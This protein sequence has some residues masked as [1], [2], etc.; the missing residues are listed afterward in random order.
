[1]LDRLAIHYNEREDRLELR[2]LTKQPA[3]EYRFHLTRRV[4][5]DWLAQL[6]R[7][8]EISASAPAGLDATARREIAKTHHQALAS[9]VRYEKAA[10]GPS[11]VECVTGGQPA[12][13]LR[14]ECGRR[15]DGERWLLRFRYGAR[16]AIGL[17]VT[18]ATLHGIMELLRKRLQQC[19]WGLALALSNISQ[20]PSANKTVH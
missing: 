15:K 13:L 2:I 12:L 14:V 20:G 7:A 3:R 4:T 17:V 16:E 19:Q 9:Q 11:G 6:E 5:R 18:P 10:A 1:M 8:A